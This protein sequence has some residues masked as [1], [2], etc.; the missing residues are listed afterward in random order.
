MA[1]TMLR[2]CV[3]CKKAQAGATPFL[4][5]LCF[6][7]VT[8]EWFRGRRSGYAI[9]EQFEFELEYY[10]KDLSQKC[11]DATELIQ[12]G[13]LPQEAEAPLLED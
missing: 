3:R 10:R 2:D 7:Q 11:W 8:R 5:E 6:N 1:T 4:C 13:F 12:S 9:P